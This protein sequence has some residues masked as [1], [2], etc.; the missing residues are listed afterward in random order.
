MMYEK[1]LYLFYQIELNLTLNYI[2]NRMAVL[3]TCHYWVSSHC[4]PLKGTCFSSP[5]LLGQHK[6]NTLI[7]CFLLKKQT[8]RTDLKRDSPKAKEY[9][10]IFNL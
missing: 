7:K 8:M 1:S 3:S 4:F 6:S 9:T 10:D 2:L 5:F